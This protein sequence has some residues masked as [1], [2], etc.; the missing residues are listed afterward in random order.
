MRKITATNKTDDLARLLSS[1][2]NAQAL[3]CLY[4]WPIWAREKQLPPRWN[5]TIWLILSGRGFGKTRTGA[6]WV[7]EQVKKGA[8]RVAIVGATAADA[9][10]VMIE[11]DSGIL[12]VCPPDEKLEY[13]PS[14]RRVTWENGAIASVYTADEPDRLRGPQHDI[15]WLD[16]LAAWRYMRESW[17]NIMMGLRT[18]QSQAV[19]TTTPR[20]LDLLRELIK[21][22]DVAVVRGSTYENMENL[23]PAFKKQV[24]EQYEGTRIGRQEIS[25]EILDDVPGA[26]WKRSDVEDARVRELPDM[27]RI[28]VSV[29]PAVSNTESSDH[30]GIIICGLGTDGRGY[31]LADESLRA[32]PARWAQTVGKVYDDWKA[33]KI[34]AE[35]NQGG[36]MVDYTIKS[37]DAN[38]PVKLVNATRGKRTRAEPIASLYEQGRVKHHGAF[39]KLEDELCT[40]DGTGSSPD[41]LD[42]MVWGITELMLVNHNRWGPA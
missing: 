30:T 22:D 31:V 19:A 29:D 35:K 20:P 39:T 13:E 11:G 33:D 7:R 37:Y 18:G 15:A 8:R 10:D 25:G 40:W 4:D 26:L 41:R 2:T 16:E 38:L 1:M 9:R 21:R 32:S 3:A 12:S 36:D 28:I 24:L 42:A 27:R 6:E 14:K 5:W 34:I 23:S 17:D